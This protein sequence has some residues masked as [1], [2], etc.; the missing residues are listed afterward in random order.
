M[1]LKKKEDKNQL[2]IEAGDQLLTSYVSH[3]ITMYIL[4]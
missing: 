4:F 1:Y 2:F 3:C